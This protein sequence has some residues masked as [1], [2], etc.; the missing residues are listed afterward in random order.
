MTLEK[1]NF[2]Y[3][4]ITSSVENF[5]D[6]NRDDGYGLAFSSFSEWDRSSAIREGVEMYLN[7]G[8][9]R[10]RDKYLVQGGFNTL[11]EQLEWEKR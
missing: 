11:N 1:Q 4:E 6:A 2:S 8:Y 10:I 9:F 5:L 3:E 7:E